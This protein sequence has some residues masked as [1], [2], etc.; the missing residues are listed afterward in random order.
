MTKKVYLKR[1][2][3]AIVIAMMIVT[4]VFTLPLATGTAD[5]Y[6]ADDG[7]RL[8]AGGD[9]LKV[10]V[11][12]YTINPISDAGN[13]IVPITPFVAGTASFAFDIVG[14]NQDIY[15]QPGNPPSPVE[16]YIPVEAFA[17]DINGGTSVELSTLAE[18]VFSPPPFGLDIIRATPGT[19]TIK[20][21][22]AKVIY[23]GSTWSTDYLNNKQLYSQDFT[24]VVNGTLVYSPNGGKGGG[25]VYVAHNSKHKLPATPKRTGYKFK[26]WYT[27][28]WGGTKLSNSKTVSFSSA[29][30][31][32]VY[33]Q[34]DKKV[35][36]KYKTAQG[37]LK[38]GAKTSKVVHLSSKY[39]TLPTPAKSGYK[40]R[41]WFIGST[42]ITKSSYVQ[43]NKTHT[44]TAKWVKKGTGKTVTKAEYK[45]IKTGMTYAEVKYAIGGAGVLGETG[46][47]NDGRSYKIYVWFAKSG[48]SSGIGV[49]FYDGKVSSKQI[50]GKL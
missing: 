47:E 25:T 5:S 22:F 17:A 18:G 49:L 33:A 19:Y 4:A 32:T 43:K 16:I 10:G 34:W 50:V 30:K 13:K 40:F 7:D 23:D 3:S 39:G 26:G 27:A 29:N 21:Y 11:S 20:A 28:K 48:K 6:A 35:T 24:Y 37:K 46:T 44:L 2:V 1:S 12:G 9:N 14:K 36:V 42:K 45:E 8:T 31:V 38:K 15:F 41:G